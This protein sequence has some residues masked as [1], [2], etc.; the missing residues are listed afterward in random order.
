MI[1]ISSKIF[2]KLITFNFAKAI[3]IFPFIFIE[4]KKYIS[5]KIL[6]NH[7]KIHIRQQV[8]LLIIPFYLIYFLE[9]LFYLIKFKSRYKAY[10]SI[11]FEKEA[12]AN[13]M[14]L[15]YLSKRKMYSFFK[16]LV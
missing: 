11:S 10:R 4:D 5:E 2:V 8:E 15:E 1:F 6:I 7:E 3:T 9:F 13:E 14:D 16:Y 12:Y